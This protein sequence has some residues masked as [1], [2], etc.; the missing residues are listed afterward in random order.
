MDTVQSKKAIIIVE[1]N[2]AIAEL[3][4]DALNAEPDY[5]ATVVPD[6]ALALEVIRSVKANLILLD[7]TLPGMDGLQ[8]YDILKADE[9]TCSIPIIFVTASRSR[10]EFEKR[11]ITSYI[12]KPFS[13]DELL[14]RVAAVCRPE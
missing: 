5:L 4:R 3:M 11:K 1:D 10:K 13:L 14:E 2:E 7:V 8:L 12:D 9:A 6:G